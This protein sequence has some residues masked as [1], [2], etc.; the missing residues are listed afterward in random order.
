GRISA[1]DVETRCALIQGSISL[2]DLADC[3]LI[4]EAVFE[5]IKVKKEIFSKLDDIAKPG[6]ILASNTSALNLNDIA[7]AT[8]RP[9]DVIGLHFFSPANVMQLLE[10]VR[11]DKTSPEVIK[12]SMDFAKRIKK[13]AVLVGVCFG[14]VGNRMLGMR[15]YQ[16]DKLAL[17]GANY[18]QIDKVLF[19]F[20]FPMGPF[21]MAD[22]AGLDIG[23]LKES[24]QPELFV[25]DRLC[26][27]GELG[28]KT[29]Q[30]FYD[31]DEKRRPTPRE[32]T[33][34]FYRELAASSGLVQRSI[35][36]D[37]ILDRLLLP[38]I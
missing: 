20:G 18:A 32:Q 6:A 38:M 25:K 35:S 17:E 36:D 2:D 26:E 29:G 22:L 24:S 15:Q 16:S 19:D 21:Q 12:T 8:S 5:D 31:Y 1:D 7:A 37:E 4:I 23:W 33:T 30:G 3:D 13:V 11:G 34:E 28:Q 14:F 27:M 10:I 9:E